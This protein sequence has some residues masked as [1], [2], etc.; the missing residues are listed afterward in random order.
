MHGKLVSYEEFESWLADG[1]VNGVAYDA[2]TMYMAI[3]SRLFME[4]PC[5]TEGDGNLEVDIDSIVN[6]GV[7]IC[8][9]CGSELEYFNGDQEEEEEEDER[10]ED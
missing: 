3:Q 4:C 7:P 10:R 2:E 1:K 5:C 9:E 6:D 8:Q